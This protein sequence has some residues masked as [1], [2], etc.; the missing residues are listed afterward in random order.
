MIGLECESGEID[1]C[2]LS[3]TMEVNPDSCQ[4]KLIFSS[5]SEQECGSNC[6]LK[7]KRNIFKRPERSGW[8]KYVR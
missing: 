8:T 4:G 1:D 5:N 6:D 7:T 3:L 2:N